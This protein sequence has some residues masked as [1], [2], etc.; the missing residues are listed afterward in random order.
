M[1][2][3]RSYSLL[4]K[5][6]YQLFIST[7]HTRVVLLKVPLGYPFVPVCACPIERTLVLYCI[8]DHALSFKNLEGEA[9]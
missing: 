8:L 2:K 7:L 3:V 9:H 1:A 5:N 4:T 6:I